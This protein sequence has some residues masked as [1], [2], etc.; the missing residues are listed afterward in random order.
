[1]I[2]S[3]QQVSVSVSL[4]LATHPAWI[5]ITDIMQQCEPSPIRVGWGLNVDGPIDLWHDQR[6]GEHQLL[7]S[8]LLICCHFRAWVGLFR[9]QPDFRIQIRLS[10]SNKNGFEMHF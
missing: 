5:Q 3:W 4:D 8:A 1:M 2:G 7:C 10:E 6:C 9:L